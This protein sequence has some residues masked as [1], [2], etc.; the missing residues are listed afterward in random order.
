VLLIAAYAFA[1]WYLWANQRELIFLPAR[2]VLRTPADVGLKYE[3][4]RVPVGPG[5][6]AFLHGWWLRSDDAQAPALLYLHGNDLNIGAS[7]DVVGRLHGMGFSVL[8]VDYRGYGRSSGGLPS[9]GQVYEDAD[10]AWRYLVEDLKA[11]PART[12]IYGHSLGS[13]IAIDLAV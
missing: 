9:E 1:T 10:A 13:A 3:D 4:V 11:D 7:I 12:F 8:A 6:A 2:H 5:E